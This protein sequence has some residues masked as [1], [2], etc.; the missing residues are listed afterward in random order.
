MATYNSIDAVIFSSPAT[1]VTTTTIDLDPA[2]RHLNF[3]HNS[4]GSPSR[5]VIASS[6]ARRCGDF[7]TEF[8]TEII[9]D[10]LIRVS[11][12]IH[13]HSE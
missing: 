7:V 9:D 12:D 5:S 2:R 6:S 13:N 4:D 11:L 8:P 1:N 10:I 3:E